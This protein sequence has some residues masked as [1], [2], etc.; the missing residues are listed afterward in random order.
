[1]ECESGAVCIIYVKALVNDS[2]GRL[3]KLTDEFGRMCKRRKVRVNESKSKLMNCTRMMDDKKMNL[4]INGKLFE[5]VNC[6]KYL[7]SYIAVDRG[8]DE[9]KHRMNIAKVCGGMKNV[10]K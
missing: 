5:E 4:T 8:T 6:F 2:E 10:F 3:R 9:V 7:K 1:M